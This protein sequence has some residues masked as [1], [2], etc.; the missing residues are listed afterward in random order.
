MMAGIR[1]SRTSLR[2][3]PAISAATARSHAATSPTP[4]AQASPCTRATVGL[5]QAWIARSIAASR[6]ASAKFS[7]RP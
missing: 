3:K 5:G 4:P 6:P 1:P 7:S 2:Q